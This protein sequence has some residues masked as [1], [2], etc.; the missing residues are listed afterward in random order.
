[1]LRLLGHNSSVVHIWQIQNY[2][3]PDIFINSIISPFALSSYISLPFLALL[4]I[5]CFFTSF[6]N[7]FAARLNKFRALCFK[8]ILYTHLSLYYQTAQKKKPLQQSVYKENLLQQ[9]VCTDV[10]CC[11]RKQPSTRAKICRCAT[12]V[13]LHSE[14]CWT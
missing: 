2:T 8:A 10:S 7:V 9:A 14:M 11:C 13:R 12:N 3:G 6:S 1:M 5:H 4:I